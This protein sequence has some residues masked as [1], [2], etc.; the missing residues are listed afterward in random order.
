MNDTTT[1]ISKIMAEM[2]MKKTGVERLK[3]GF[4]MFDLA[5]KIAIVSILSH[6]KESDIRK[7]LFLRFY[8]CDMDAKTADAILEKIKAS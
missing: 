7:E 4:S 8:K 6:D 2:M 5:K 3:M 1:E